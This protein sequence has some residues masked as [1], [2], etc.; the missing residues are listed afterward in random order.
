MKRISSLTPRLRQNW[1]IDA[2]L[3]ISAFLALVS[4]L[5]FLAFPDGGYRG[6]RNVFYNIRIIFDRHTWDLLHTYTGALMIFAAL[7][8]III[9]WGWITGTIKRTWQVITR[10]REAFGL[11][12][13]Y[14]ILLDL[15]IALGFLVC[16]VS[17]VVF[18]FFSVSG[19]DG[20]M[21]ILSKFTWDMLH[22]WSGIVMS[23][24]AVLHILLHWKWIVNISGKMLARRP[25]DNSPNQPGLKPDTTP[26]GPMGN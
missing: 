24:A 23:I 1:W 4:S 22:T 9:H 5:Y 13:I 19:P 26:S 20:A 6:G 8:H 11:R 12:L 21:P 10:Q 18:M 15:G 2:F 3:G 7:L 16:A 25:K 14:N 17:G